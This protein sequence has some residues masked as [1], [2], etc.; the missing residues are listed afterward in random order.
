MRKIFEDYFSEY[1][2]DMVSVCLEYVD[3]RA[4]TVYIYCSR[5]GHSIA[6]DFFFNISGK[7]L[8]KHQLNDIKHAGSF[9]YDTSDE[10]QY[11]ATGII[12]EDIKKIKKL[13]DQYGKDMPTEMKLIYDVKKNRLAAKYSYENKWSDSETKLPEDIF[14]EWI[15]DV[16]NEQ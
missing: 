1:Q 9:K 12:I 14:D 5:E 2:A 8:E 13:C 6:G 11:G 15:E 16:R 7:F 4:D 3:H 10:R